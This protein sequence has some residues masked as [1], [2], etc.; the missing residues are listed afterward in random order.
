MKTTY[1]DGT[2]EQTIYSLLDPEWQRD[3]AGR[4]THTVHNANREVERV[5]DPAGRTT[6]F[7]RCEGCGA[8]EGIVD[9][10]GNRTSFAFD[11]AG[12]LTR[13]IYAD[14]TEL[15]Y[16]YEADTSRLAKMTDAKNQVTH[17]RYHVD[18][19]LAA[20]SYTN[21]LGQPLSPPTAGVSYTYEVYYKR[22]QTMT[23]EF[24][25]TD[26][27]YYA[28]GEPGA[29]RLKSE[30]GPEA[31]N[32]DKIVHTY[33][34]YGRELSSAINGV[35]DARTYDALGHVK[36]VVNP[37][38]TFTYTYA[39]GGLSGRVTQ[40]L[41]PGGSKAEYD[42]HPKLPVAGAAYV[43]D[44]DFRLAQITNTRRQSYSGY[45]GGYSMDYLA[46]RFQYDYDKAGNIASWYQPGSDPSGQIGQAWQF[47]YD[48]ADQL[49]GVAVKTAAYGG[50][51]IDSTIQQQYGYA[52]DDAGN[53]VTEQGAVRQGNG[54]YAVT[55]TG[56]AHNGLNQMTGRT[57]GSGRMILEGTVN[58]PATVSVGGQAAQVWG[59][60]NGQYGWRGT[61]QVAAGYAATEI[62]MC[63]PPPLCQSSPSLTNPNSFPIMRKTILLYC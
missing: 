45:L 44:K 36:T 47:G 54:S 24:G 62:G 11:F 21:T 43:G 52:Y 6:R 60:G 59:L 26:F 22:L 5:T 61:A 14:G 30:N 10:Q 56:A 37:L 19:T 18:N 57:G 8:L 23:D 2:Y 20:V 12:R 49:I 7:E 13:K 17:Y 50:A 51:Y 46:S 16:E 53:R 38:G 34:E 1:P 27:D 28:A 29:G 33:D 32:V 4:W 40:V 15:Q 41:Y 9:A 58:E 25:V 3:R 48:A 35:A 42:Y 55:L 39:N 31:G 63:K